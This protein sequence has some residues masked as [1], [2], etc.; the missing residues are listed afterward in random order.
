MLTTWLATDTFPPPDSTCESIPGSEC[1]FSEGQ[2]PIG[3]TE[4]DP[5]A[6]SALHILSIMAKY[7]GPLGAMR[8][9]LG[10]N[11]YNNLSTKLIVLLGPSG[12]FSAPQSPP[13]STYFLRFPE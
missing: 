1:G 10:I 4:V 13:A 8:A 12:L 7:P 5:D 6:Q 2:L 9:I 11:T 3:H